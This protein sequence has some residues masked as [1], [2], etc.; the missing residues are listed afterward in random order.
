MLLGG[1]TDCVR[2]GQ[3]L[4]II[5]GIIP[6]PLALLAFIFLPNLPQSGERTWGIT[7]KEHELSIK[8]MASVGR[9]GKQEWTKAKARKILLSWHT[10]LLRESLFS[11]SV[12]LNRG[13]RRRANNRQLGST[14]SGTTETS[15]TPSATG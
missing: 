15:R 6:I 12:D 8:R 13:K 14:S 10:Y 3:W 9:A 11:H 1:K 4:F 7:E 2:P 5:D